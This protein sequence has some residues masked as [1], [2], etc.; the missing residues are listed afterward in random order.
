MRQARIMWRWRAGSGV[1]PGLAVALAP[2]SL[3]RVE[4]RGGGRGAGGKGWVRGGKYET[5]INVA[6]PK[7]RLHFGNLLTM[8]PA[9]WNCFLKLV[10]FITPWWNLKSITIFLYICFFYFDAVTCFSLGCSKH[11]F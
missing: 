11:S 3:Q 6:M 9:V 4:D 7:G 10:L 8:L 1:F 2:C 5:G